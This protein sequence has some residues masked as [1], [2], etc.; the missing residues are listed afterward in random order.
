MELFKACLANEISPKVAMFLYFLNEKKNQR[1]IYMALSGQW[2]SEHSE[3][4]V[5]P[6]SRWEC[7]SSSKDA[8]FCSGLHASVGIYD[9]RGSELMK[10]H[11]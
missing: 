5:I 7:Q 11:R 3:W 6:K 10:F 2:L 8:G 1:E 4:P 9:R